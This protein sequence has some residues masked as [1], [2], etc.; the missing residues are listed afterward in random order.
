MRLAGSD[1]PPFVLGVVHADSLSARPARDE[2]LA[3]MGA[4]SRLDRAELMRDERLGLVPLD[5]EKH[6]AFGRMREDGTFDLVVG[7]PPYVFESG[8]KILFDRLRGLPAWKQD[9]RGKSDYLYYFLQLA[10]E[11]VAPGGRL[12]VITPAGWMNAGN[13]DWL[14]ENLAGALRLDELFLFGSYRLFAPEREHREGRRRAPTPTVESA[15]LVATRADV[16]RGHELRIVAL[17]DEDEAA[18]ARA[19]SGNPDARLPDRDR[20]LEEMSR[21]AAGRAG[22]KNGIHV[23]RMRQ[24][25]L[26]HSQP[27]P[28]KH[29]PRDVAAR[30][31]KHLE[32]AASRTGHL[33]PLRQ[34]WSIVRG[35]ETGADA[36]SKRIQKHLSAEIRRKLEAG[37]LTTGDPILELPPGIEA[38]PPWSVHPEFLARSP[39]SRA[40]LYGAIDDADYANLV[41]IGRGDS[42]PEEVQAALEPWREVLAARA[43]IARNQKRKWF[44]TAW[45]RDKQQLRRPKVIALY[46]TDRGRF[47]LDETG[48]WVP[49]NKATICTAR[50]DGLSVA[51]LCGLLNSELLDLWYSVR[52][53]TPRDVWRNYEPKPMARM[54]YRHVD[55]IRSSGGRL[56]ELDALLD[57]SDGEGTVTLAREMGIGL[58]EGS[59]PD[60]EVAAGLE[61]VVRAVAANRRELLPY[62]EVV[63]ELRAAVKDPWR[64]GPLGVDPRLLLATLPTSA[65]RSVRVDSALE[66]DVATDGT[67]G[68]AKLDG[69]KLSFT[70]ARQVTAEVSGP[71]DRLA[72]VDLAVAGR[73]QLLEADLLDLLLPADLD[74][75]A[76]Q[77]AQTTAEVDLLMRHGRLLVEAA[78]RLVCALYGLPF[79]LEDAVVDHALA[80]AALR[81]PPAGE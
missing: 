60:G 45:P 30:V 28:I 25:A 81:A 65:T 64:T 75:F 5:P 61:R 56:G 39:E 57:P 4:E 12:C 7:N 36:Y 16:P 78:E 31:V 29:G 37:G 2:S 27:W 41:W 38:R 77:I 1:A 79:D 11:K 50:E 69:G 26:D 48:G 53:K 6:E 66:V 34:R 62:R 8:N 76:S 24:D 32:L 23:H 35:I 44:E 43:E 59:T 54:P 3:G 51:Y 15:I 46:R 21:R 20:L 68:R 14:R 47:A 55:E 72:L 73:N 80:R 13:A 33:E 22:R 10:A 9:Y 40:L 17:E 52:G 70:R 71:A 18:A 42:P 19:I 63:P 67:L 49:S 58:R 74:A